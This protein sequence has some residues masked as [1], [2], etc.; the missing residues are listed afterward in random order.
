MN[1][2]KKLSIGFLI[3]LF[4]LIAALAGLLGTESGLRIVFNSA[5]RWVPGLDIRAVSGNWS[6]GI[7]LQ[8]VEYRMPGV[9]VTVDDFLLQ[10]DLNCLRR[11]EVCIRQLT[12]N[13]VNVAIDTALLP[14]SEPSESAP[15]TRIST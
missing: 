4:L 7:H 9:D 12:T 3:T 2:L 8:G 6:R 13:K 11:S 14:P 15:L 5:A 1:P 10:L